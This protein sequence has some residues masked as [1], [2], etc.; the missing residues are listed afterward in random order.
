[1]LYRYYI[2]I[3]SFKITKKY[4][5]NSKKVFTNNGNYVIY[6]IILIKIFRLF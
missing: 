4:C 2:Y 1:M 3:V 5:K 6:I